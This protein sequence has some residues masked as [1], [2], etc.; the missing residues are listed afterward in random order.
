MGM[1]SSG[2]P[3]IVL[4]LSALCL[5]PFIELR[6]AGGGLSVNI[7]VNQAGYDLPT[8]KDV[9]LQTDFDPAGITAFEVVRGN[10]IAGSGAW[11]GIEEVRSW[12]QWYRRAALPPLAA[13]EYRVRVRWKGGQFESPPFR[14]GPQRL[15]RRTAPLACYFFYAQRCGCVIP[16]WHGPCHLDDAR[17]ADGSHRDLTGGWHDAGDYN[18][19]NGY[20]PLAVYAL[21][22]FA[23]SRAASFVDWEA[24]L[25]LPVEESEWGAKWLEKSRDSATG[26]IIGRVFSGFGFWGR[27]EDETDN[28]SGNA[29]DRPAEPMDWNENEMTAAA[30]AALFQASGDSRWRSLALDMWDIV[31]AADPGSN[32]DRRAKR[33]LAANELYS[34]T[35]EDRF[36][37]SA[38]RDALDLVAAQEPGG[39][40]PPGSMAIVDYGLIPAA[41]AGFVQEF[42]ASPLCP[43]V[44]KALASYLDLWDARRLRPF[45]VPMWSDSDAFYPAPAGAWYVGQNSMYLSQA[46]AGLRIS[47][48]LGGSG[49]RARRWAGGC[50][51]WV[52][53]L[54][55]FGVCLMSE[56]GSVHLKRYHHRYD[57]VPNGKN[58]NVPGA[59]AN[60]IVR[61]SL[62]ED[63][64]ELDLEGNWWRTNEP[65]LP[66]NAYYLLALSE[67]THGAGSPRPRSSK[68][69]TPGDRSLP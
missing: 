66:H 26:R 24:E 27:P 59:I 53:G 55:P 58:G 9:L 31:E 61:L 34:V 21:A 38:Q 12:K 35:P 28:I 6:A 1:K 15:A 14:I 2:R 46:W 65:W 51:D 57:R 17:F 8:P 48:I 49:L 62:S 19:Y 67:M 43:A 44:R 64:P 37:L 16:G 52:L 42:P 4:A 56:A 3:V 69:M 40:W 41:L 11:E 45:S 7:L 47:R 54:N 36:L 20:A 32:L 18:K 39:G 30:W 29:D 60:G 33:L 63:V 10:S 22:K 13:G 25:P 50:L 68:Q 23:G 5:L